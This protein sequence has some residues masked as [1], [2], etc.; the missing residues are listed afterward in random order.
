[1]TTH[2][3]RTA[4]ATGTCLTFA[5][6]VAVALGAVPRDAGTDAANVRTI[7]AAASHPVVAH[8]AA[9]HT[10]HAVTH[11]V[12]A[13]AR[14]TAHVVQSHQTP[15]VAPAPTSASNL[16]S[17]LT[18]QPAA[19]SLPADAANIKHPAH[20]KKR[21]HHKR[22]HHHHKPKPYIAP[23]TH[24]SASAVSSAIS[25]LKQYVSSPF[26]PT[27]SQVAQFGSSVCTAFDQ[28]HTYAYVVN[29]ITQKVHQIPFTSLK[30]GG[31]DYVVKTAVT[32][33]CPGYK[34]KVS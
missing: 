4:I 12:V 18:V 3:S 27:A 13:H 26:T 32:L 19:A 14:H 28:N 10:A 1:V 15:T 2:H 30:A 6:A 33:Y 22:R 11:H 31:A 5:V 9:H 29:E 20:H 24:P 16:M 34:S 23:R 7:G 17:S 8:V 21:H 25:G